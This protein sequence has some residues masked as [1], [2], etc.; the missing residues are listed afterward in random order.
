MSGLEL[1]VLGATVAAAAFI[2]GSIGFGFALIA[3][4]VLALMEPDALP[5][6]L[7]ILA[8]PANVYVIGRERAHVDTRGAAPV[9]AGMVA[10]TVGGV[11]VLRLV[12]GEHLSVAFGVAIVLA[13]GASAV[14]PGDRIGDPLRVGA[15][16]M[17]GAVTTVSSSG[18]PF[19]ALLYQRA[20]GPVLRSTLATTFLLSA[21]MSLAGQAAAGRIGWL[22]LRVAAIMAPGTA[23]GLLASRYGGTLVDRRWLRPTVLIFSAAS[24]VAA[25]V[26]ALA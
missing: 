24:G 5:G 21:A 1:V 16:F 13:A 15:G 8:L 4:P 7:L 23:L 3:A 14:H 11:A 2:Q 18:G 25:I 17:S 10:G 6:A 26:R 19:V 9:I 22:H 12:Q 20:S